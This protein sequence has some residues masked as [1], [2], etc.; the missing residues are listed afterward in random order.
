MSEKSITI[1]DVA[2][3]AG[4]S[5]QTVSNVLNTPTIVRTATRERVQDAITRLGYSPHASARR[6]RTRRSAT[7]G[8]HL[9]PYAG[10]ISGVVLDRFVHALT[11]RAGDRGLRVLVYA[12]SDQDEEI[13]RMSELVD[14]GDVE[15]VVVTGTRYGDRRLTWLTERGVPFV[16]FG[17]PWDVA[18]PEDSA[19]LWVDVDGASGTRAATQHALTV[20]PRVAFLG[21]PAGSPTGDDRE[22]GWRE[23]MTD[24][25]A[26]PDL[27][28]SAE[29]QVAEARAQVSTLLAS[30]AVDAIV[31]A[32]D[33]L[34]VGAHVAAVA[35]Q[36]SDVLI[37][38]FDNT[39]AVEALGL[40]SVEQLPELVAA[41][42]LDLLMGGGSRIERRAAGESEGHVLVQPRLVLR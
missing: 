35:A 39:P 19:H 1:E 38:G 5:R 34:A 37:I 22:R 42:T 23:A 25:G 28:L 36:R 31:C 8:I 15:A 10:G 2:A 6:L 30:T 29:E 9:D 16:S 24:A 21:W 14:A 18:A 4:V 41:G 17:R 11:E 12:A 3:L 33:T 7:I 40:S 32:S 27:R 13:R 26:R 20:G